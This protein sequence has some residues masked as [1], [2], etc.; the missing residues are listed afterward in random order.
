MPINR[1]LYLPYLGLQ[2][3]FSRE[4]LF[5][6]RVSTDLLRNNNQIANQNRALVKVEV[7]LRYLP[8]RIAITKERSFKNNSTQGKVNA[9][10]F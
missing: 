9:R 3:T 1:S 8:T 10:N 5:P 2:S 4:E 7:A 6:E